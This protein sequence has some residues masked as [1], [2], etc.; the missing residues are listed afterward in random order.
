MAQQMASDVVNSAHVLARFIAAE[1]NGGG[2]RFHHAN[3]HLRQL[4]RLPQ[5]LI[6]LPRHLRAQPPPGFE[7]FHYAFHA[8]AHDI[9]HHRLG[10]YVH[11]AQ[12]IGFLHRRVAGI[13]RDQKY[14][15]LLRKALLRQMPHQFQAVHFRHHHIQQHRAE[16]VRVRAD[17]LP[18]FSAVFRLQNGIVRLENVGQNGPVDRVVIHDQHDGFSLSV[19]HALPP[20]PARRPRGLRAP[21]QSFARSGSIV[22]PESAWKHGHP[23][24][25]AWF[26]RYLL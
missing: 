7:Q 4:L 10:N 21:A 5:K 25:R 2:Q 13:R 6:L 24:P 1:F 19:P 11:H 20:F 8:P 23:C 17:P 12:R 26:Y 22:P 9:R 14:R 3:P 16:R 18:A 15:R